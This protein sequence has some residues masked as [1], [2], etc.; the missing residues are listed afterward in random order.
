MQRE[1]NPGTFSS[2]RKMHIGSQLFLMLFPL[3][4]TGSPGTRSPEMGTPLVGLNIRMCCGTCRRVQHTTH[5]HVHVSTQNT[6]GQHLWLSDRGRAS[7]LERFQRTGLSHSR[8]R[9][10]YISM[11]SPL[12]RNALFHT[13]N[14]HVI[15][16]FIRVVQSTVLLALALS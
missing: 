6:L 11:P 10:V 2:L 13:S 8:I 5:L 1:L 14:M 7:A 15:A 16:V 12:H 4:Q 9:Q 3:T